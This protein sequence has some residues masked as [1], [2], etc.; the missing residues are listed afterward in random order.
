MCSGIW[1]FCC[2]HSLCMQIEVKQMFLPVVM[3][4]WQIR[5]FRFIPTDV[6]HQ[7]LCDGHVKNSESAIW[8]WFSPPSLSLSLT[9]SRFLCPDYHRLNILLSFNFLL[10]S[11]HQGFFHLLKLIT[12]KLR[13]NFSRMVEQSWVSQMYETKWKLRNF[14]LF[15]IFQ[16]ILEVFACWRSL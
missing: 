10:Y 14:S 6:K 13:P 2:L 16:M 3:G 8:P 4:W 9:L 15:H 12:G 5:T 1:I 11:R 7:V